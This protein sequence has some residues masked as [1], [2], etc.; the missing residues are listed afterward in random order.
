MKGIKMKETNDNEKMKTAS[1]AFKTS[2]R[3]KKALET[4]AEEGFRSLSQQ[5]EMIVVKHLEEQGIDWRKIPEKKD[6][7]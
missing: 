3:V 4:L 7:K 2:P 1:I 5:V 6:K